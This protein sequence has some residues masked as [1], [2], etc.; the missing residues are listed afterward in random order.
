MDFSFCEAPAARNFLRNFE[1][2]PYVYVRV[3]VCVYV[4]V[5]EYVYVNIV[6][7]FLNYE[8]KLNYY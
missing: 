6:A 2:Y 1:P 7:K 4:Y 5:C 8:Y 3:Y